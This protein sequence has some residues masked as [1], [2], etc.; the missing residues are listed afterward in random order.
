MLL[1]DLRLKFARALIWHWLEIR[2]GARV[3]LEVDLD[4]RALL[5]CLTAIGIIDLTRPSKLMIAQAGGTLRRRF[6]RDVRHMN[7]TEL[8]P[9]TLGDAGQ[10]ACERVRRTPCGFYHKFTVVP[11]GMEA[12]TAET[13]VLPLMARNA[14]LPHAAIGMT[15]EF[16][17][18]ESTH[19]PPG[20]LTPSVPLA[21]YTMDFVDI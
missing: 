16:G 7:W 2:G 14:P 21:H 1:F 12:V 4:P 8:V 11:E 20:W 13:L 17:T 5:P 6:G 10:Q 3:P 18:E 9:P 19:T 15:R